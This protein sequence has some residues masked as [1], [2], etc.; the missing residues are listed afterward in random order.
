MPS[1]VGRQ[2]SQNGKS[3]QLP[4]FVTYYLEAEAVTENHVRQAGKLRNI[5]G[6]ELLSKSFAEEIRNKGSAFVDSSEAALEVLS[7]AC[8]EEVSFYI[9]N[10]PM[11][12]AVI[13]EGCRVFADH[14]SKHGGYVPQWIV[15][16]FWWLSYAVDGSFSVDDL[17]VAIERWHRAS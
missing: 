16:A 17:S 14:V 6:P 2:E 1:E 8:P 7:E 10:M 9:Y 15:A 11:P 13:V 4:R 3:Q 5:Y 12:S